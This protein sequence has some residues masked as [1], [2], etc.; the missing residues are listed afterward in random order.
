M[1]LIIT[2]R[3]GSSRRVASAELGFPVSPRRSFDAEHIANQ[4]ICNGGRMDGARIEQCD[5]RMLHSPHMGE[6]SKWN[7]LGDESISRNSGV[8]VRPT[9]NSGR[10]FGDWLSSPRFKNISV[11]ISPKS[12]SKFSPSCPGTRGVSRS[13]R[14]L[15]WD[16]ADAAGLLTSSANADG[17]VVWS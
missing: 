2:N 8:A 5:W 16:A 17:E 13:S 9:G 1:S 15:G 10:R 3:S 4:P 6:L 12:T 14:T 11:L 7:V